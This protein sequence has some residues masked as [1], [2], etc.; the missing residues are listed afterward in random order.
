MD[1]W[2]ELSVVWYGIFWATKIF[3]YAFDTILDL[4]TGYSVTMG[5]R[6][7]RA[8]SQDYGK[9][10]HLVTI[11]ARGGFSTIL[12]HEAHNFL[13]LHQCYLSPE[14]ILLDKNVVMYAMTTTH[15]YFTMTEEDLYN[16]EVRYS[17][18]LQ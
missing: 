5:S 6:E 1:V 18:L 12:D 16:V 3:L 7:E 2:Q 15:A 10:A 11:V 13:W 17:Y 9:S 8:Q 4:L 14:N